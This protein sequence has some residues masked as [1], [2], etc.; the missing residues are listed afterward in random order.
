MART[1]F[2]CLPPRARGN[3]PNPAALTKN[4]GPFINLFVKVKH[5][6]S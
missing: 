6:G 4:N 2:R 3:T 1:R 5:P